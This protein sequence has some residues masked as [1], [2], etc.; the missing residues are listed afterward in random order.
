MIRFIEVINETDFQPRLERQATLRFTLGEVW[1][2]EDYVVS[3]CEARGYQSL[4]RE[5]R[6][7]NDLDENHSFTRV[8]THNGTVTENHVVLGSPTVVADRLSSSGPTLLKG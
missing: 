2:N 4:L 8:T 6:L 1:I 7:P 5:G 3:V